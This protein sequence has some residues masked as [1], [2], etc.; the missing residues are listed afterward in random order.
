MKKINF[1]FDKEIDKNEI[2]KVIKKDIESNI[3][4]QNFISQFNLKENEIVKNIFLFKQVLEDTSCCEAKNTS[5]CKKIHKGYLKKLEYGVNRLKL[6][7]EPCPVKEKENSCLNK[8]T[9]IYSDLEGFL[10]NITLENIPL[11]TKKQ[12]HEELAALVKIIENKVIK[13]HNNFFDF[14]KFNL[15]VSGKTNTNKTTTFA[16]IT[17]TLAQKL[18]YTIAY[19][20]NSLF[21]KKIIFYKQSNNNMEVNQLMKKLKEA[22]ILIID[23]VGNETNA[24]NFLEEEFSELI[25]YRI[26]NFNDCRTIFI[27]NYNLSDL[28]NYYLKNKTKKEYKMYIIKIQKLLERVKQNLKQISLD[29]ELKRK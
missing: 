14:L 1:N 20:D 9:L 8:N 13:D 27:S 28:F 3:Y 4:C 12:L 25:N 7:L 21:S 11:N 24:Y 26:K 23:E 29:D 17:N 22:K 19:I 16:A 5:E 18:N 2:Y 15:Y 6:T 10:K